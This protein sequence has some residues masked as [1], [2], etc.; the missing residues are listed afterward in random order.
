MY[1]KDY[2]LNS[3]NTDLFQS[4]SFVAYYIQTPSLIKLF[5]YEQLI[6]ISS[7]DKLNMVSLKCS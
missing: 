6:T 1:F 7:L 3:W 4:V 2:E 5:Y